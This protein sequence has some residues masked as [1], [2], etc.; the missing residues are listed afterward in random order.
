MQIILYLYFVTLFQMTCKLCDY[1]LLSSAN[2]WMTFFTQTLNKNCC[3]IFLHNSQLL[4]HPKI[5]FPFPSFFARYFYSFATAFLAYFEYFPGK[6]LTFQ[7]KVCPRSFSLTC[8]LLNCY[9][10][11]LSVRFGIRFAAKT[12]SKER[13]VKIIEANFN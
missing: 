13:N 6:Y 12:L 7:W 11:V 3:R 5:P 2:P 10:F 9:Y 4:M 8:S 1:F